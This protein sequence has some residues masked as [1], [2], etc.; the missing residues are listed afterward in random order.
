MWQT[1]LIWRLLNTALPVTNQFHKLTLIKPVQKHKRSYHPI[2]SI[3]G[4]MMASIGCAWLFFVAS[5]M[6]L[7]TTNYFIFLFFLPLIAVLILAFF[8]CHLSVKIT[9]I[10]NKIYH[11]GIYDLI[12]ITPDG[13]SYASLSIGRDIYQKIR[14]LKYVHIIIKNTAYLIFILL[15]F[16]LLSDINRVNANSFPLSYRDL[17]L[18]S[19]ISTIVDVTL[20]MIAIYFYFVQGMVIGYLTGLWRNLFSTDTINWELVTIGRFLG[21]QLVLYIITYGI[22]LVG[23]PIIYRQLE[24]DSFIT[25]S[26]MQLIG[27]ACIHEIMIRLM[28]RLLAHQADLPY[29][30]WRSELEL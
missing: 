2:V 16:V 20:L 24:W 15:L 26:L 27:L 17:V 25:L 9:N 5:L 22:I 7:F 21:I 6:M 13:N 23:L 29:A 18:K 8:G 4:I 30:V 1:F 14:W 19:S 12:S 28:M 3:I 11:A 10:I